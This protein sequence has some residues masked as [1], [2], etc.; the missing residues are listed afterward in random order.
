[1]SVDSRVP[2]VMETRSVLLRNS[3]KPIATI[4]ARLSALG[5]MRNHRVVFLC[6]CAEAGLHERLFASGS[7]AELGCW[8]ERK[9][10]PLYRVEVPGE[11]LQTLCHSYSESASVC[12]S[13]SETKPQISQP[14][15]LWISEPVEL[16]SLKHNPCVHLPVE[17]E[18]RAETHLQK[19]SERRILSGSTSTVSSFVR[20]E[21][22]LLIGPAD[23]PK[24]NGGSQTA[25]EKHAERGQDAVSESH[26][27]P[28]FRV[29]PLGEGKRGTRRLFLPIETTQGEREVGTESVLGDQWGSGQAN[30]VS[31][32]RSV[33]RESLSHWLWLRWGEDGV[34]SSCQ[35]GFPSDLLSLS[36]THTKNGAI[37]KDKQGP[38]DPTNKTLHPSLSLP[39]TSTD[40]SRSR[41][42]DGHLPPRKTH[43]APPPPE[44]SS[45]FQPQ[46]CSL[47]PPQLPNSPFR[48][49]PPVSN[50]RENGSPASP[51][52]LQVP[53]LPHLP[54]N[55]I[56]RD[57]KEGPKSRRS[58]PPSTTTSLSRL[59]LPSLSIPDQ[60]GGLKRETEGPRSCW[61]HTTT[62]DP[63]TPRLP[64][65]TIAA[66]KRQ[67]TPERN[68]DTEH[69]D[70]ADVDSLRVDVSLSE[71]H[72]ETARG[73]S[74]THDAAGCESAEK[75]RR[76]SESESIGTLSLSL[77]KIDV[78]I[79]MDE[80]VRHLQGRIPL[81]VCAGTERIDRRVGQRGLRLQMVSE[82]EK[83]MTV[84]GEV[85][86]HLRQQLEQGR[87]SLRKLTP[88]PFRT[89]PD[90]NKL[91]IQLLNSQSGFPTLN[92]TERE[93]AGF[94]Q[95]WGA[96][97]AR[98]GI[99]MEGGGSGLLFGIHALFD[100]PLAFSP[101]P[102]VAGGGHRGPPMATAGGMIKRE[103]FGEAPFPLPLSPDVFASSDNGGFLRER[104]L[105]A[106]M[107][108]ETGRE[109]GGLV[110]RALQE[111]NEEE[112][113]RDSGPVEKA[114]GS[115]EK[116]IPLE[117]S[118]ERKGEGAL[119]RRRLPSLLNAS[120]SVQAV[121]IGGSPCDCGDI[122]G[123][124]ECMRSGSKVDLKIISPF[125]SLPPF[126]LTSKAV[127]VEAVACR[128]EEREE[129]LTSCIGDCMQSSDSR[130]GVGVAMMG[131]KKRKAVPPPLCDVRGAGETESVPRLA[132]FTS[133]PQAE[134]PSP[135]ASPPLAPPVPSLLWQ[136]PPLPS[137][138]QESEVRPDAPEGTVRPCRL[139]VPS[140]Q[141]D[142]KSNRK[143]RE[144][145]DRT[146]CPDDTPLSVLEQESISLSE[147]DNSHGSLNE[148]D[149]AVGVHTQVPFGHSDSSRLR[150]YRVST[151]EEEGGEAR[152]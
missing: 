39:Q 13:V 40:G 38:T 28:T 37:D 83:G 117:L 24:S 51:L 124:A 121:S 69:A 148:G 89:P 2:S 137:S 47:V 108:D 35:G 75:I 142:S 95:G 76:E 82:F 59:R 150:R 31:A 9:V 70:H 27:S 56:Q 48:L 54:P 125:L 122:Q 66:K 91:Q 135:Y 74:P 145:G 19:E 133:P 41:R 111:R 123:E 6:T 141:M 65:L 101:L 20:L 93:K 67:H 134:S 60:R 46:N 126:S 107:S 112:G 57:A 49:S 115:A 3:W 102:Q 72:S 129:S 109:E 15:S 146:G 128:G 106:G 18:A 44:T 52:S 68:S 45:T 113:C 36:S 4:R 84:I 96:R 114:L 14:N 61:R 90:C 81:G 140:A 33:E 58:C 42:Q 29:E 1:M 97:L 151:G 50:G 143:K 32:E 10:I 119:E 100:R 26:V 25:A 99:M 152:A 103:A 94:L 5:E 92:S 85:Q 86:D 62:A 55:S 118:G 138:T 11:I 64:S 63:P 105:S 53:S 43:I 110:V 16:R 79:E 30:F 7:C 144:G 77:E 130:E 71:R 120:N 22:R 80:R 132:L 147:S 34:S 98:G 88:D 127:H 12:T 139:T 149:G 136:P 104:G 131:G 73:R 8:E 78:Q 21:H 23:L 116:E 87:L 17:E